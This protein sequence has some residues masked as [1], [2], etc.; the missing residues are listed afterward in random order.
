MKTLK[1]ALAVAAL[2]GAAM[3]TFGCLDDK[4]DEI[5]FGLLA[6]LVCGGLAVIL[7]GGDRPGGGSG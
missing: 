7:P 5:A 2:I 1:F 3:V 6:V 4:Q